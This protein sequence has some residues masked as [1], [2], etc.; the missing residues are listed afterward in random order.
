MAQVPPSLSL[1]LESLCLGKT[2]TIN[3]LTGLLPPD[4]FS[5]GDASIYGHS[6][7]YEMDEIRYSMGVCPQVPQ[8]LLFF[9]LTPGSTMFSLKTSPWSNTFSSSLN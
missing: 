9:A 4:Y 7:L 8:S 6:V 2:T 1:S 3:M 5:S